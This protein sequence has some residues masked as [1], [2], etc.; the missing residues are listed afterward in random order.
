MAGKVYKGILST[1]Q[2]VA[3]KHIIDEENVDTV[4]R[5]VMSL[6]HVKHPNLI[7]LLGCCVNE[8]ECFLI[9]ELC[10]NGNLSEWLFGTFFI[11]R[12]S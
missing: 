7:S 8:D 9:Y 11:S 10:P 2:P 12:T 6:S 4:V 3:I 1:N 5:E